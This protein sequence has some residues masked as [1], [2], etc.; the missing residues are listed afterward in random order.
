MDLVGSVAHIKF[1][2]YSSLTNSLGYLNK[3]WNNY[4]V[5]VF[6]SNLGF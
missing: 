1:C 6:P 2:G 5:P 4:K 3:L